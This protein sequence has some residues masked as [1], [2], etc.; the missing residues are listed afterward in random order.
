[1]GIASS[2]V[3]PKW[4]PFSVHKDE[5]M[6]SRS[7]KNSRV[8]ARVKALYLKEAPRTPLHREFPLFQGTAYCPA[9]HRIVGSASGV[10]GP[11]QF[12]PLP[13]RR[14]S[15]PYHQRKSL[16]FIENQPRLMG[17]AW[18]SS[19]RFLSRLSQT[20]SF[21]SSL[22]QA[23]FLRVYNYDQVHVQKKKIVL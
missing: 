5:V 18:I 13:A 16:R 10:L 19:D 20:F 12:G 9:R 22:N 1:M 8:W 21:E 7:E 3:G 14:P 23:S 4:L 6:Q 2:N 11:G 15:K 17:V